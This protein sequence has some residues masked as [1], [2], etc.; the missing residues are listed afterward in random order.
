ME[1]VERL[2]GVNSGVRK[3]G[4]YNIFSTLMESSIKSID[5]L[6]IFIV[7]T[8]RLPSFPENIANFSQPDIQLYESS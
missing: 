2:H 5:E 7:V 1:R 4:S 8:L 6:R 3:A